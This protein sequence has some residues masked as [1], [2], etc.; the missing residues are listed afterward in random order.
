MLPVRGS[1][2]G[3]KDEFELGWDEQLVAIE[4][5]YG[6]VIEALRLETSKGRLSK[7]YGGK[8][9]GNPQTFRLHGDLSKKE[10]EYIVGFHGRESFNRVTCVGVCVRK[11]LK[12]SVFSYYWTKPPPRSG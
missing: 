9:S 12:A 6:S 3:T 1:S 5:L 8:I 2:N 10:S 11:V 4:L 7:W